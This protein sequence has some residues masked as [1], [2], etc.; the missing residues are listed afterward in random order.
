MRQLREVFP[1]LP[2]PRLMLLNDSWTLVWVSGADT[3]AVNGPINGPA[4]TIELCEN[5]PDAV[6]V[7]EY[8]LDIFKL[9][10]DVFQIVQAQQVD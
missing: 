9:I 8:Q 10:W 4:A 1:Q 3:L 5:G 7:F 6:T 2:Q